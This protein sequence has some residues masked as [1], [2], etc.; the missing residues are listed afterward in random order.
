[1]IL[2]AAVAA[3][4]IWFGLRLY[5]IMGLLIG[6]LAKRFPF[7]VVQ[8]SEGWSDRSGFSILLILQIERRMTMY[9]RN[10]LGAG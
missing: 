2:L 4:Q 6:I 3:R 9:E 5:Q 8:R 1:L 7:H 10:L